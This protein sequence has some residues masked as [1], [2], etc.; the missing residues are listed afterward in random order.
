MQLDWENMFKRYVGNSTK[1]PYF[2]AVDKL[3]CTQ[4]KNEI[5]VFAVFQSILL[6]LFAVASLSDRMPHAGSATVTFVVIVLLGATVAY[7]A[8]KQYVAAATSVL[9]PIAAGL[10]SAVYGFHPNLGSGDKIVLVTLLALWGRYCW[11]ILAIAHRYDDM[12][13]GGSDRGR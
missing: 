8:T 7:G 9:A 11:R 13:P 3:D 5:F 10:Y 6:G 2:V 1:T 12:A 4:A